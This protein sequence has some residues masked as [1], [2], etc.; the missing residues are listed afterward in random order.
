MVRAPKFYSSSDRVVLPSVAYTDRW[1]IHPPALV[2]FEAVIRAQTH[3]AMVLSR[4]KLPFMRLA[5]YLTACVLP[6]ASNTGS[7]K[8]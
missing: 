8:T 7:V 3:L 1:A 6:G 5:Q 4:M 2:T